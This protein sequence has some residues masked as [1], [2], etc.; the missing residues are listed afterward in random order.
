MENAEHED[1]VWRRF[2]DA[3]RPIIK[4][5]TKRIGDLRYRLAHLEELFDSKRQGPGTGRMKG[6]ILS[7]RAAI[8]CM[9]YHRLD[10]EGEDSVILVLQELLDAWDDDNDRARI[11]L[12]ME[13]ARHVLED[14]G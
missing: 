6:E 8:V 7:L 12:G 13:R 10:V 1:Q 4:S 2:D 9:E 14:L 11:G 3:G 5:M